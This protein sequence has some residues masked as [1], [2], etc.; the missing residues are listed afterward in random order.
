M[1]E[2]PDEA[3]DGRTDSGGG[4]RLWMLVPALGAAAVL[5]VFLLG[6]ERDDGGRNLPSMLI[7]K[8]APEFA[9]EPLYPGQPG[10]STADLKTP[11]VKLVN[12]WASWCVSCRVEVAQLAQL[13]KMG[14]TINSIDYKD[15][16]E[17]ADRFLAEF[18]NPYALIGVD[19]T[20]RTGID[21]GVY[22]MPE[23]FV[24][25]GEGRI[26]YRHPGPIQDDDIQERIL[27]AIEKARAGS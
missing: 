11:G 5:A 3:A 20:G 19:K 22:G 1:T 12:F 8:P 16:A 10:F 2:K 25:D 14:I 7:G 9:L 6:L 27:P 24:I 18:G 26:V 23:T 21:F 13:R 15:T 4:F 17:A